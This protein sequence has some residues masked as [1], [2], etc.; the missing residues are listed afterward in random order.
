MLIQCLRAESSAAE[1]SVAYPVPLDPVNPL[2]FKHE[3]SR[4]SGVR[5]EDSATFQVRNDPVHITLVERTR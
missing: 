4:S 1:K 5:A 3:P 2:Q